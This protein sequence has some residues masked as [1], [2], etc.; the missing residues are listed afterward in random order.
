MTETL[1][2]N[3]GE[4]KRLSG[5]EALLK[6]FAAFSL[7][8]IATT[9]YAGDCAPMSGEIKIGKDEGDYTTITDAVAALKCGG[10]N[11][12]VTFLLEDGTY[13]EKIDF[14]AISGLSAKNTVTFESAKGNNSDVVISSASPDA[15][16]TI[17]FYSAANI[18]FENL[19]IENR[20]GNTGNTVRIDGASRNIRFNN[21]VF[22]GTERPST[23]ANNAVVYST[24]GDAKSEIVLENCSVNNGSIGLYKGG[25]TASDT[26]TTIT[27]TLF[28]NQYESAITLNNE[29][30]PVIS[31][32]VISTVS[33][34]KEYKAISL[35]KVNGST[36]I[37]SNVI[38]AVNGSYGLVLKDCE[39][40]AERYASVSNNSV[41][42]GGEA[43]MYGL[44]LSG[45]TDNIVFN[46]NRVK[47]TPTKQNASNQGY[48]KNSGTGANINLL[49]NIFFDLNT[50]GYTILGNTYKDYFNQL[51]AQSNP[52]LNIGA[53]GIMIEKVMPA[54]K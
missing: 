52:S 42:V 9:A 7:F 46:F 15:P 50:G 37:S 43:T 28:F 45:T 25:G 33:N 11:G 35:D 14:S 34:Y 20:T 2:Y 36:I 32:N 39:A 40:S 47:L 18:T 48:Y 24:S 54:G 16:Y 22:N 31:S 53:N 41:N 6:V 19:T 49:N 38:N 21:V 8:F 17:G 12:P 23:G 44:Y 26:R 13:S 4:I 30:A 27:G 10:A 1:Y 5:L 3:P 51:P 29:T